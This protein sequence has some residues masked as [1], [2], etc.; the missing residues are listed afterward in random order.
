MTPL[1]DEIA[2]RHLLTFPCWAVSGLGLRAVGGLFDDAKH[3]RGRA[4]EARRLAEEEDD[5][6]S[7]RLILQLAHEYDQ[8]AERAEIGAKTK[9]E[10][11]T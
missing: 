6:V 10:K 3:W 1:S 11:K 5:P 4:A 9:Q 8:L 7:K 2:I